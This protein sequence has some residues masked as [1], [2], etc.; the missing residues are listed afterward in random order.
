MAR[1]LTTIVV[2][3]IVGYSRLM[4]ADETGTLVAVKAHQQQII[5]PLIESCGGRV[6][7]LM[8]D[9]SLLEFASVVD[10]VRF[11]VLMQLAI[12]EDTQ[13]IAYRIG[14]NIG[15]VIA[16]GEDL[17][18]DGVNI[19]ARLEP[20]ADAGGICISQ[21][22]HGQILGKLD[23]DLEAMGAHAVKNIPEPVEVWRVTMNNKA[24]LIEQPVLDPTSSEKS[25]NTANTRPLWRWAIIS[26]AVLLMLV[27]GLSWWQSNSVPTHAISDKP[28]IAIL[29]FDN[30]NDDPEQDYF[31]DGI[32]DDLIT[33]LSKI[34]GLFVTARNSSFDFRDKSL[35][36]QKIAAD[37]GVRYLLEGSVRR[38]AQRIRINARLVDSTTG[39][40]IWSERYD[41]ELT[42][43]FAI[44]DEVTKSI[45]AQ[46]KVNLTT[47]ETLVVSTPSAN[48]IDAYD[49]FLRGLLL[50]ARFNAE[51]NAAGR[52][53][54][55]KAVV[56]DPSY[57]R[58]H[59]G[60]SLTHS[61]DATFF[62]TQ[63]RRASI[64]SGIASAKRAV[65][66]DALSS[67]AHI[68][69]ASLYLAQHRFDEA[70]ES[71]RKATELAPSHADAYAQSAATFTTAGLHDEALENIRI[72]KRLNPH[73]SYI[74]LYVEAM[75]LF[76][77][78]RFEEALPLFQE[79]VYRNPEF[80]RQQLLLAST[81]GHLGDLE[82]A[83]WALIEAITLS[84]ALS[85]EKE[86][87]DHPWKK[88]KDREL[89]IEGL[90]KAGLG[91]V[92]E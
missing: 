37:L 76:Y 52:A 8:G 25:N 28:S 3:D 90:Q 7:K 49:V 26:L 91:Y 29:P 6:V 55:E 81:L 36:L 92:L 11:A 2:T 65:E 57:A 87:E 32:A 79:A 84:P 74:Y 1:R 62:W 40:H 4:A 18:G 46:L 71:T 44:Q 61:Y 16:D 14:I 15:D 59:A 42:D 48:N 82:S 5:N 75:T 43:V 35:D 20:L 78:K 86:L 47:I 56:L 60:I 19:A 27:S 34:S 83:E 41:R 64:E 50:V 58:A 24:A 68:A 45:V 73:Y 33:D 69:L 22:A 89:Y 80:D 77:Q 13:Q 88:L 72:A 51:D 54:Y 63:D 12:A 21:S 66:L 53:M 10:S 70:V 30:L 9:G 39:Q 31:A 67:H 17:F 85:L 38:S 23:L